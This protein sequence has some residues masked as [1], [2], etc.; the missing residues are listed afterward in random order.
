MFIN[1]QN[2]NISNATRMCA[3]SYYVCQA[4]VTHC[5]PQ[6]AKL[7]HSRDIDGVPKFKIGHMT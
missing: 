4:N 2:N 1:V 7:C 5:G 3:V 6:N